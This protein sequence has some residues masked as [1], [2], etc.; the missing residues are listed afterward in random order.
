M[1][2]GLTNEW[3]PTQMLA[4]MLTMR[5][6]STKLLDGISYCYL[7]DAR[8]NTARSLLVIGALLGMDV[9]IAAPRAVLWPDESLVATTTKITEDTGAKCSS[10]R[11][12]K[13]VYSA[14][15]T[16]TRMSGSRWE[17]PS[18]SGRRAIQQLLPYQVNARVME[19]TGNPRVAFMHDLPA[20]HNRETESSATV[21]VRTGL[22]ALEVTEEVFESDRSIVFDQA[23]N[24]LHTIKAIMVATLGG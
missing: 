6:H 3:H 11:T 21:V 2:N 5:E 4:D 24:R 16:S 20:L 8:N 17:S 15:I 1:W 10:P 13:R 23:E 19:A 22:S 9:R 7:G 12:W 18:N 14:P